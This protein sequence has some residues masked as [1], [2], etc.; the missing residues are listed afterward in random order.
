MWILN[1]WTTICTI[2]HTT[3]LTKATSSKIIPTIKLSTLQNIPIT[4]TLSQTRKTTK[5]QLKKK[6]TPFRQSIPL[7]TDRVL[8]P[9]LAK[10]NTGQPKEVLR[11]RLAGG[12]AATDLP[13]WFPGLES[14]SNCGPSGRRWCGGGDR[15]AESVSTAVVNWR[16]PGW[17]RWR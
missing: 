2:K 9:P 6:I 4:N 1:L 10:S 14:Y 3:Y 16:W 13:L 8:S 12:A 15:T 5:H 17:R 7:F 11:A